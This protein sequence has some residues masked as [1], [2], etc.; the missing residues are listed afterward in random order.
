MASEAFNSLGGYSIGIPPVAVIDSN[1]N[2]VTNVFTPGNVAANAVYTNNLF[3]ANGQPYTVGAAG[4]NTQIQYNASG[5]FGAN[6][7]FTFNSTTQLLNVPKIQVTTSANLGSI[8]NIYIGGGVDGYFLQTDGTGNLTWSAAGGG[9]GNGSPGGSNTQIQYNDAGVFGGDSGFTYNNI[10]NTLTV[11]TANI[12]NIN[13]TG[14]VSLG[15]V[16]NL[17]ITGGS[18]NYVLK[19]DGAGNLSWAAQTGGNGTPGGTNTQVQFN[20]NGAFGGSANFTFN[21]TNNTLNLTNANIS[22]VLRVLGNVQVSDNIN[23]SNIVLTTNITTSNGF[24]NGNL[25]INPSGNLR[26]YGNVNTAGSSN[27][28]L[29]TLSNI[30]I[31]GGSANYVL[32]TDG[33]GNLSWAAQTGGNGTPGGTNTQVQFNNAGNFG[34]VSTFLFDGS[35]NILSVPSIT[36]NANVNF[37]STSNV[38]LGS[39]SNVHITG[40]LNGYVLQTDGSGH[41]S[42]VAQSG[43]GGNGSPGGSNTQLQF[44]N[45]GAFAGSPYLTFNNATNTMTVAGNLIANTFQMG[46]GIYE[47]YTTS[48]YF[49][50]TSSTT[51]NQV[52][53]SIPVSETSGVDFTIISTTPSEN[54][55]QTSKLCSTYYA[56]IVAYNEFA[57]LHINGGVGTFEVVYN[58]GNILLPPS[59]QLLVSPDSTALTNYNMQITIYSA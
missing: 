5:V 56:G 27:I 37:S 35:T 47:F 59:L 45:S 18:A 8:A 46:A 11:A 26:T 1:G 19:T 16:S 49:A 41:L 42:W 52:L 55:R 12:A 22:N 30:H 17:S 14:L 15:S 40:G 7:N 6:T 9:G 53:W 34:G 51:P 58:A 20:S 2:V 33:A 57:G 39:I 25:T 29:G 23:A 32:K 38:S 54:T 10:T 50:T 4:S 36:S 44:N 13:A 43:G 31:D 28:N 48:V 3:F 21:T 24:V